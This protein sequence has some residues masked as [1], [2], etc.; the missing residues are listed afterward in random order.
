MYM[1]IHDA[2]VPLIVGKQRLSMNTNVCE[3]PNVSYI[4]VY[5]INIKGQFIDFLNAQTLLPLFIRCLINTVCFR[6]SG[7]FLFVNDNRYPDST[8]LEVQH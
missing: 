5:Q 3:H 6:Y 2:I 8:T 1:E 7:T 4:H